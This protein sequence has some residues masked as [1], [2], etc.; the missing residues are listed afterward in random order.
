M[1]MFMF[2]LVHLRTYP[3]PTHQHWHLVVAT[4]THTVGERAVCILLE[5]CLVNVEV[6]MSQCDISIIFSVLLSCRYFE[7]TYEIWNENTP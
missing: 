2:K 5:C 4:E 3:S 1:F 7:R 6:F